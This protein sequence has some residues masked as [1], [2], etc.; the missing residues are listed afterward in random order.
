MRKRIINKPFYISGAAKGCIEAGLEFELLVAKSAVEAT[1]RGFGK[2]CIGGAVKYKNGDE[3]PFSINVS[4]DPVEV[5]INAVL[6]S[7]GYVEF[8]LVDWSYEYAL[9]KEIEI[10]NSKDK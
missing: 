10:Y 7:R 5:G 1:V 4:I 3:P 8:S 6:K 2:G 9:T